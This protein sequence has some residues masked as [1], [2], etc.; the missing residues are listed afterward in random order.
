MIGEGHL[1]ELALTGRDFDAPEALRIGLVNRVH[2]DREALLT[3][4]R[5]VAAEVAANP[6]LAVQ[7]TKQILN[8]GREDRVAV[9]LRH[10]SAWNAAF[11]PSEDLAE[12]VNAFNERRPGRYEGR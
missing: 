8:E 4:A 5:D 10:V 11:L 6:P 7:G 12:A 1:R 9:G 3:A 2:P